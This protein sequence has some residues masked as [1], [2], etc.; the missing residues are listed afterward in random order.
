VTRLRNQRAGT[1]SPIEAKSL[2]RAGPVATV[3]YDA[4]ICRK[5]SDDEISSLDDESCVL[6]RS[7]MRPFSW[8]RFP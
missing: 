7:L 3:R 8:S 2:R 6:V 5:P 1:S 4:I